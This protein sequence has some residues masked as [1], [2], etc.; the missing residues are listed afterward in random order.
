MG[1]SQVEA[2]EAARASQSR[3]DAT[4][5]GREAGDRTTM[6][7]L[8]AENDAA[9]AELALQQARVR[10]L[11]NRLRLAALTGRL[12]EARLMQIN[13]ALQPAR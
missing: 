1:N 11:T 3:L 13:A 5:M 12:D 4:H 6:E 10:L 2:L 9:A 8:N 7:L